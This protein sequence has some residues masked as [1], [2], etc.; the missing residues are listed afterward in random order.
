MT[1]SYRSLPSIQALRCFETT[2]RLGSFTLAAEEMCI[3]HSAIS[4]QIRGLEEMIGQPLFVRQGN[5][6][7]LTDVGR[8]L[9]IETRR[10]L[11]YLSQAYSVAHVDTAARPQTLNL[12][13]QTG[14]IE[15]WLLPRLANFRGALGDIGL[16]LSS[17]SDLSEN[18]P[19]DVD[20]AL[21]YGTGDVPG[22][23]SEKIKDEEVFPVC[24]PAFLA[25]HPDFSLQRMNEVPLLL[26]SRVT[27]NLWL[28]KADLPIVYPRQSILLDD[29]ALTI[30]GALNGQGVA[31]ARSLLVEDY[32]RRGELVR[33]FDL[34]VPGVF[35]Y[36]LAWRSKGT[37][38]HFAAS[39]NWIIQAIK[40]GT[41]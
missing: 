12:A 8:T 13:A 34:S 19:D 10:A 31:M 33:L 40:F 32:L 26:H 28:E 29:I 5:R 7:A 2:A 16:R 37:K 11:D 39:A 35:S 6:M 22:M 23:I 30:R 3:T 20:M 36:Y 14:L 41:A 21:V 4:H 1:A 17:L 9:A 18:C 27:W 25:Q 15:H 38:E 24:S